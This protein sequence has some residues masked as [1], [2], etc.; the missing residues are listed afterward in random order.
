MDKYLAK[1]KIVGN[2]FYSKKYFVE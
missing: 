2:K 1:K